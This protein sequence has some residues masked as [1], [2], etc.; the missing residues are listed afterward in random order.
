MSHET[1]DGLLSNTRRRLWTVNTMVR[2]LCGIEVDGTGQ[3]YSKA[4]G[5]QKNVR[6]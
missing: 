1:L 6:Q 3:S 5:T 4:H 2:N